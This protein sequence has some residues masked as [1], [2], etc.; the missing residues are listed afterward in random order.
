MGLLLVAPWIQLA[1]IVIPLLGCIALF[2][3]QQ[4]KTS[5]SLLLTN[6]GC[7]FVNCIYLLM[8]GA[9]SE[10]A[11]LMANKILYLANTLFFFSF[12]L[13]IA[14]YLNLGTQRVRTS[15]LSVWVGIE[16]V[17]LFL[18]FIGDPLHI[19]FLDVK[20][21]ILERM[22]LTLVR[23][24]PSVLYMARNCLLCIMLVFGMI[25]STI[26]M[27]KVKA[28]EERYNL[29]RLAGAQFVVVVALHI[30]V[31]FV[32]P[33]DIVPIA[34]SLSIL[35]II[36]G[37][38]RGNF[39]Y[40][41]DRGRD[42][43][44]EHTDNAL[45]IVD[46][47]YGYLD[48]NPVAKKLFPELAELEKSEMV[49]GD[50]IKLFYDNSFCVD[51]EEKHYEKEVETITQNN[52]VIGYSMLLIDTTEHYK[53]LAQIEE[54]KN[55]VEIEK[56]RA[57]M[58]ADRA[59]AEKVRAE[60]EA[61]RAEA[62][63]VRAEAEAA[64]AEEA[65]KAKSA[66]M[67]NMSHE[68]R[69]PMNAI[70]GMTDILLRENL[71]E[72]TREYL[73]NI[74]SSGDA[75]LTIINDILDFSK[76]EAGKMDIIMDEY[77]PM[78]SFH[79]LSM[80]F[81]NRI[82]EKPV[83]LLY[84]IDTELPEKLYGD[85]QRIRQVIINLMNNAI[86]FTDEG[87]VK[88]TVET[89]PLD[90]ET[91]EVLYR[92]EDSGQG[93]KEEDIDKLFGTYAQ[94]DK[95]KN[96]FKEGTGLG[97]SISKQM[98]ELMGGTIGVTSEYGKGSVFYF[99]L[100]QKI[101]SEKKAAS[102]KPQMREEMVVCGTFVHALLEEQYQKLVQTYGVKT[103]DIA[104]VWSGEAKASVIFTD[105]VEMLT[106]DLCE[107]M[108][109][110]E[111][112]LCVLQNPMQQNLSDK[113]AILLNKPFYSLNFC[114]VI[115]GEDIHLQKEEDA[116]RFIAPEAKILIVDD[117]EM[118]LKV[119]KGLL[120]P[121]R[122]QIDTA[123]N[124]KEAIHK[125]IKKSY[126]IV[127]MDHMMPVMDGVEATST[128][129]KMEDAHIQNLPIVAL[130]ANA[131]TEARELFAVNGFSDFVPK[132]IK[133]KE[134]CNCIRRWLP[135]E[136]VITEGL[137]LMQQE[138][139]TAEASEELVIE[140]LDVKE[141]ILNSGTKELF[142]SLLGDFYK[143]IDQKSTKV[144]KCLADGMIRDYTIEVHALKSTARMIGAMELSEKFYR[145]EKLGNAEDKKMLE[146]ETPAVLSLYRSYKPILEPFAKKEQDKVSVPLEEIVQTLQELKE[147]MDSFD[148]D[149]AD[150]AMHRLEGFEFPE[151]LQSR[152][153]ELS[154]F[155]ADV[156]MED[157]MR[158]ADELVS[159]LVE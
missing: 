30:R 9:G 150:D 101:C 120:E 81:L 140:G 53:L 107:K 77:E 13:F 82:G 86:K 67:S 50:V 19:V 87:F 153:E 145:L 18:I 139:D 49:S 131:T 51:I 66:F 60:M 8:L 106:V 111:T 20:V 71:P 99:T 70:V 5:M 42:W 62:E 157:V 148:L 103:V 12:M 45:I 3:K 125:I 105:D 159:K 65:N 115:N 158:L 72:S 118:N 68:I 4:T 26:R 92:I 47:K 29:A 84:D 112:K 98:V 136:L 31:F 79:D 154:A 59:E 35:A 64:R 88:L 44:I 36:L 116:L 43:V 57:E 119:A 21:Q 146:K 25:V 97:L 121:L 122:M 7:L 24:V 46:N 76:I 14:T 156:A 155:V 85:R 83:E 96:H 90:A 95:E 143:L 109:S 138:T 129:R 113:R 23:T 149:G 152:V 124:G 132:P 75:L 130:S 15:V 2:K 147:A 135:K 69:T 127:F 37:V 55:R 54:E 133:L 128:L 93:I 73:N 39:F 126:D 137:E 40:V 28:L 141:G 74:R 1:G 108:H 80:I 102:V 61:D 22:G 52:R 142:L 151:E 144:E 104:S 58:E 38:I 114:Q 78:S 11:A 16:V 33:Y 6:I 94:V 91:V 110:C 100:P 48:A 123:E 63:K 117:H 41:T 34:A 32:F 10:D 134:L 27:F 17:F 89:K 56:V